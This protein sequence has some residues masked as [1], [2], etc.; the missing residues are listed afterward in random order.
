[1]QKAALKVNYPKKKPRLKQQD[2]GDVGE[3]ERVS[4]YEILMENLKIANRVTFLH[5]IIYVGQH[6]FMNYQECRNIFSE[7]ISKCNETYCMEKL[8]GFLLYYR[9]YFVHM[10]EGDED[11]VNKHLKYL[12]DK[13]ANHYKNLK[14]LKLLIHIS[15]IN[16]RFSDGWQPFTGIPSKLLE[17]LDVESLD[18]DFRQSS[19]YVYNCIKKLYSL[20]GSYCEDMANRN[21]ENEK[22]KVSFSVNTEDYSGSGSENLS[23]SQI[24]R[25]LSSSNQGDENVDVSLKEYKLFLPEYELL[26]FVIN[27]KFTMS[28]HSYYGLYGVVPMREIYKDKV[29]PVPSSFIPYDVFEKPYEC[30][31]E[32]PKESRYKKDTLVNLESLSDLSRISK[33]GSGAS[34]VKTVMDILNESGSDARAS[35]APR[36]TVGSSVVTPSGEE[37]QQGSRTGHTE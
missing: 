14:A 31:I 26:E 32:L 28:L 12:L 8:T 6:T 18:V 7:I 27:S 25:N 11:N 21:V 4:Q 37:A 5:R 35:R 20:I 13:N 34:V 24:L 22:V 36:S 30:P 23:S 33:S 19:R 29:W 17:K 2:F 16:Q 15:N 3:P 10:V 1:M 9:E